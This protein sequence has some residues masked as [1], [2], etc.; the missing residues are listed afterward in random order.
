[1][2]PQLLIL[3][4]TFTLLLVM[5][6]PIA[7]C[8]AAAA[9]LAL[10]STGVESAASVVAQRMTDGVASFPLLAIPS[11]ILAGQLMTEGGMARRLVEFATALLGQSNKALAYVCT[12][13][14]MM[15]GA[16]SGSATAAVSGVGGMTLPE[17][18]RQ[19][20]PNPFSVA[21]ITVSA[22]TGLVIPP[23]NIMIVYAVVAGNVSV[24]A[25]FFAGI[26]PGVVVGLA[27]MAMSWLSM[28]QL[29]L[30]RGESADQQPVSISWATLLAL[31]SVLLVVLVLSGIL[32]G[33][34]SATEAAAIAVL[35]ALVL[36]VVEAYLSPDVSLAALPRICLRSGVTTAVIFLLIGASQS[37]S[38]VLS[39]ES[40]PQLVSD[41]LIGL[42]ENRL[43]ILLIIN[44]MLLAV[45]TFMDMT[46]AVLIFA[47]IL[48][49]VVSTIGIH[50][51]H[52]GMIM[53]VNLCIGL[54]TPPVGTCLFVG[55]GVGNT[56]IAELIRPLLPYLVAMF[57]ALLLITYIPELSLWLPKICGLLD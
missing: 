55:C 34:F 15:F 32:G 10:E 29:E 17:M 54:C 25:M 57:I 5:D 14:C 23:S 50:P 24:A 56:K 21:L 6:V 26:L 48:L 22:T 16:I 4:V 36:Y 12:F 7:V 39:V 51:V 44:L 43:A 42:T 11:F 47:P 30:D 18:R 28:P 8:L 20:Y 37:M 38:W 40:I 35:Y 2:D 33:V 49:P 27:I 19:G 53:V 1:M 45:G 9:I 3:L 13:T 31:P 41:G 46:P 52:F